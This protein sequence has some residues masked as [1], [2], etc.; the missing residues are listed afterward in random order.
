MSVKIR[1]ATRGSKLALW[2]A[3]HVR[4]LLSREAGVMVELLVLSTVGDRVVDRPLSE[5]GG[6]GLFVKE[7]EAALLDG[8]ADVAVHSMKDLP[9][10]IPDGLVLAAVPPRE[11]PRDA[12]VVRPGI[13]ATTIAA[14]PSGARVGTSSLRRVCQLKAQRPDLE[15]APLRGNVDTRLNRVAAGELDAIVLAVAGLRRLGFVE[16]IT[17]VLDVAESLPAIGQGALAIETRAGDEAVR[18]RVARFDDPATA[19]TVAA[20]RAFLGRLD[21]SCRTPLAAHAT[22]DGARIH[23]DGLVGR[24]D[25]TTILRDQLSGEASAATALGRELAERLLARGADRILAGMT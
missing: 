13:A 7:I 25:G 3:H 19:I 16:R 18:E 14:L 11:D 15:V 12:L 10:D 24:P 4:D 5:M 8:R 22:L 20:E 23:L 2:Q 6:K 9:A 17:R 1:I 21:G